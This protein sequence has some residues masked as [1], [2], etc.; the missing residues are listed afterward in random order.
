[1]AAL[2]GGCQAALQFIEIN[3]LLKER[4]RT[5]IL[6]ETLE[7][8]GRQPTDDHNRDRLGEA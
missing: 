6:A 1:M 4:G 8:G 2:D 5:Q 3:G 7:T